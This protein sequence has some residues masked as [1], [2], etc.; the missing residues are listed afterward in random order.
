[1]GGSSPAPTGKS[2]LEYLLGDS[3]PEKDDCIQNLRQR[4]FLLIIDD[5][6]IATHPSA[7]AEFHL[8]SE[9]R[10][11][12]KDS[13]ERLR[14]GRCLVM[15]LSRRQEWWL[16]LEEQVCYHLK[17]LTYHHCTVV[18]SKLLKEW[19][20]HQQFADRTST[21]YLGHLVVRL[22]F[23]AKALST[24]LKCLTSSE[25]G[26]PRTPKDLF[27]QVQ[28]GFVPLEFDENFA[29]RR[30]HVFVQTLLQKSENDAK[31][32]FLLSALQT[33]VREEFFQYAGE[34]DLIPFSEE[35]LRE[36]FFKYIAGSG[37]VAYRENPRKGEQEAFRYF[38]I[39]PILTNCLRMRVGTIQIGNIYSGIEI[40]MWMIAKLALV[41]YTGGRLRPWREPRGQKQ[42]FQELVLE[43][44]N[45]V[46]ALDYSMEG[47]RGPG[48]YENIAPCL[49]YLSPLWIYSIV[50][51]NSE[52][53]SEMMRMRCERYTEDIGAAFN[54][55]QN[56]PPESLEPYLEVL[57]HLTEY[58]LRSNTAKARRFN[59]LALQAIEINRSQGRQLTSRS[60]VLHSTMLVDSAY[61]SFETNRVHDEAV[62]LLD[63][64]TAIE[65]DNSADAR[66]QLLLRCTKSRAY[67]LLNTISLETRT[68]ISGEY[69]SLA[70]QAE[71]EAY[72]LAGAIDPEMVLATNIFDRAGYWSTIPFLSTTAELEGKGQFKEARD[73]LLQG[74]HQAVQTDDAI[75]EICYQMI[76]AGLSTRESDWETAAHHI[77]RYMELERDIAGGILPPI[78]KSYKVVMHRNFGKVF[79]RLGSGGEAL[80]HFDIVQEALG[81]AFWRSVKLDGLESLWR[82][83]VLVWFWR[84]L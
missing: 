77:R 73:V 79:C 16:G 13:I 52:I 81:E 61:I 25:P 64:S 72:S 71:E 67:S 1:M 80:Q 57:L 17:G 9:Q 10:R 27:E 37:W 82:A 29:V 42:M 28:R 40:S 62:K 5:I 39:D 58:Y 76:L 59:E 65:L 24:F 84:D 75:A 23:N 8:S 47:I 11:N 35:D 15:L 63:E 31:M 56:I 70:M 19:G 22:G 66:D 38:Q 50:A 43:I 60:S 44:T 55:V 41:N 2:T 83:L 21:K 46:S 51:N 6:D 78:P 14:G 68:G 69:S 26:S 36:Y 74:L 3:S 30:C 54:G 20:I 4:R 49:T 53:S 45:F 18:I 34:W 12:F 33:Y 32:L 7:P 48:G